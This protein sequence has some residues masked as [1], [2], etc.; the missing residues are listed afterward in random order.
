MTS[1]RYQEIASAEIPESRRE[2]GT[3]IRV[4]AGEIDG[5]QGPI[6]EIAADPTYL[7]VTLPPNGSFSHQVSRGHAAF[8]Y[9]FEGMAA[10]ATTQADVQAVGYPKLVVFGD[11][12]YVEVRTAEQGARFLLVSGKPLGEPVARYGPFVMNT[13]E[14]IRQ[15]LEDLRNGTFVQ[16]A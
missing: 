4:I 8:A 3:Q 1:P 10:F 5:I 6:T 14:E 11:G 13:K 16:P 15:A 7:D 2:D 9:L 12:D